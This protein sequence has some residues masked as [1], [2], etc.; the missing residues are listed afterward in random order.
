M[1]L[2]LW[3]IHNLSLTYSD[4]VSVRIQAESNIEGRSR[5]AT[6]E[7]TLIAKCKATGF[8]LLA[9]NSS[10]SVID[11]YVDPS[12]LEWV[13]SDLYRLPS[14]ALYKYA[15]DIY[16]DSVNL[17]NVISENLQLRFNA[18]FCKKVPV[19]AVSQVTFSP[20]HMA[21][22]ELA[23]SPD[24][25]LIYG[26]Q[27]RLGGIR[28]ISTKPIR[29]LEVDRNMHGL[30]DYDVPSGVRVSEQSASYTLEVSRFIEIR[31]SADVS[32]R[33]LPDSVSLDLDPARVRVVYR[34]T[35]PVVVEPEGNVEFWVDYSEFENSLSGACLIHSS[36]LPDG[37]IGYTLDCDVCECKVRL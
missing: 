5:L 24:S 31:S 21:A 34:C 8:R 33:N 23:V 14:Q 3:F 32:V 12:D 4:V 6:G 37:V 16:G 1:S 18:E 7:V 25:V 17:E 9:L 29:L 11:L 36:D 26:S 10:R 15:S 13:E 20:Q 30:V 19:K 27:A 22:S 35:F 28:S 2:A